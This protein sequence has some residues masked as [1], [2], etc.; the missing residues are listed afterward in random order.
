MSKMKINRKLDI[1]AGAAKEGERFESLEHAL[2]SY[3]GRG[4]FA[5]WG[6]EWISSYLL[7]ELKKLKMETYN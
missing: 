3:K 4:A 5:T 6:D 2:N 1:A 7:E